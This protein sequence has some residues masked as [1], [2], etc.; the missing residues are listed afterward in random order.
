MW[1]KFTG[2]LFSNLKE[3]VFMNENLNKFAALGKAVRQ[4]A[5]ETIQKHF[6]TNK[7]QMQGQV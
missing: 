1:D 7:E 2:P 3:N 6:S 4:E 5:R